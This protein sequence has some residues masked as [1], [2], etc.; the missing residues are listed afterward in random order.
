MLIAKSLIMSSNLTNK[1]APGQLL[2]GAI[3]KQLLLRRNH[4]G[5][6]VVIFSEL[7]TKNKKNCDFLKKS[8]AKICYIRKKSLPL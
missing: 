4:N 5:A 3:A 8:V 1:K 6:K 2:T 7:S